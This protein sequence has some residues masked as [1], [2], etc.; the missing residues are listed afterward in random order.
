MNQQEFLAGSPRC[1]SIQK[2]YTY[3][4]EV[5][6]GVLYSDGTANDRDTWRSSRWNPVGRE[7]Y[8]PYWF[9]IEHYYRRSMA[10]QYPLLATIQDPVHYWFARCEHATGTPIA[11]LWPKLRERVR[12]HDGGQAYAVRTH[13]LLALPGWDELDD[14]HCF[15]LSQTDPECLAYFQ[16]DDK[17]RRDIATKISV[18]RFVKKFWPDL[19]DHEVAA[20][21]NAHRSEVGKRAVKF[22][23]DPDEIVRIYEYGP[24]SCM[25]GMNAVRVYGDSPD[26]AVA[27][28]GSVEDRS[29]SA[30]AVVWPERKTY[31]RIYGDDLLRIQLERAGYSYGYLDGARVRYIKEHGRVVMPYL[32]GPQGADESSCGQYLVLCEDGEYE[33]ANT[34]GYASGGREACSH[35]GD[36]CDPDDLYTATDGERVCSDCIGG[37]GSENTGRAYVWALADARWIHDT[38]PAPRCD[39]WWSSYHERWVLDELELSD[40][41]LVELECGDIVS[42]DEAVETVE[43]RWYRVEECV[44]IGDAAWQRSDDLDIAEWTVHRN[45]LMHKSEFSMGVKGEPL[46]DAWAKL[47]LAAGE[48]AIEIDTLTDSVEC[49][50]DE[51]VDVL[52]DSFGDDVLERVAEMRDEELPL[53][54]APSAPNVGSATAGQLD[55][56]VALAA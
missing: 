40:F 20:V 30:R 52:W 2:L 45:N 32:D 54:Y 55:E 10:L 27:Y 12:R 38:E 34:S 41:G 3:L 46:L 23:T 31:V 13:A 4:N 7:M 24:R 49:F 15:H 29:V 53:G 17:L 22:T 25:K 1:D 39:C 28:L 37:A 6:L 50:S 44:E 43:G 19:P 35:C 5:S 9:Q 36:R 14:M 42:E 48:D 56:R 33:C 21:V 18:G 51:L 16:T 11:W 26:L 47:L 8:N